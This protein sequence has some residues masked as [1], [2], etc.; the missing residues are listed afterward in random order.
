M[1]FLGYYLGRVSVAEGM[2]EAK[3]AKMTELYLLLG[4]VMRAGKMKPT[5]RHKE[6]LKLFD[7]QNN[8]SPCLRYA[9]VARWINVTGDINGVLRKGEDHP[10]SNV[11][12]EF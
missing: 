3:Q 9:L 7:N 2:Y 10:N 6:H 5:L 4:G 1:N 8:S 12:T 11:F